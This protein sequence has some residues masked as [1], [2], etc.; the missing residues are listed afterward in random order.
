MKTKKGWVGRPSSQVRKW[1][2]KSLPSWQQGRLAPKRLRPLLALLRA[3][4]YGDKSACIR[5]GSK[6]SRD[7]WMWW[8]RKWAVIYLLNGRSSGGRRGRGRGDVISA[9][10]TEQN[11]YI[12]WY[13]YSLS[14]LI[15]LLIKSLFMLFLL[16]NT[17]IYSC[18]KIIITLIMIK[19]SLMYFDTDSDS[20]Y[21][22][23]KMEG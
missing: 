10:D 13:I 14:I 17:F 19:L 4:V 23:K 12:C 8:G 5:L 18:F 2:H 11:E 9:R 7:M 22:V 16:W 21:S 6:S 15:Y 3:P 20:E 1:V